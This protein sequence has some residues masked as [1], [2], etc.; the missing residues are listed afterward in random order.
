[1]KI[2]ILASYYCRPILV[3]NMLR[4]LREAD[5]YH[6]DWELFLVD[7]NSPHDIRDIIKAEMKGYEDKITTINSGMS[8]EDKIDQGI[9]LGKFANQA[10][11]ESDADIAL[12]IGDD[13][14]FVPDYLQKI[15][16]YY[17]DN[18]DI[19][20][21]YS[22]I[23]LFN[24]IKQKSSEVSSLQNKYNEYDVPLNP[25][26]KLDSIQVSWRL[27]C[28]KEY[29]A[30]FKDNTKQ[31]PNM[32]WAKD[33]DKSFFENLYDKCGESHPTGIVGEYKGVHD[34]QLLWHKKTDV[35]GLRQYDETIRR[36]AG[37]LI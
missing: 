17:E 5:Q 16:Q 31:V 28:C 23:I 15:S 14:E 7:D 24:P 9:S 1:M 20:C 26:N 21:A 30:W 12:I 10:I 36:L 3:K 22:K 27:S 33:T 35:L 32:P 8:F 37:N 29:G 11:K 34:Y 19:L 2:L 13:D 18:P 4:S 6:K 25:V